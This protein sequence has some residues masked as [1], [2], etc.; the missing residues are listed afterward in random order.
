[1]KNFIYVFTMVMMAMGS[2]LQAQDDTLIQRIFETWDKDSN[3]FIDLS[4]IK[5]ILI[6]SEEPDSQVDDIAQGVLRSNDANGDGHI[7]WE[8]FS[9]TYTEPRVERDVYDI[10]TKGIPKF[11]SSDYIALDKIA[12]IS[13]FRSGIGHDF[14]DAFES[15]RNM[16]H[17]YLPYPDIDW[18]T[19]PI[20]SPVQGTIHRLFQEWAGTQICIKSSQYP[21]FYF[22]IFHVHLESHLAVGDR[23]MSGQL[24]GYHI[25]QQTMSDIA[26]S[27][28]TPQGEKL[29]SFFDTMM[30]SLFAKYQ[31]RGIVNRSD[32][33]ISK[34]QRDADPL[35]CDEEGNFIHGGHLE[36]WVN[37]NRTIKLGKTNE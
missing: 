34:E 9:D 23:V 25:G 1:M 31:K 5:R 13:K 21:A 11:V 22:I 17:Y 10:N 29:I 8:E 14:S 35:E 37:L 15:K 18:T 6:V 27:I 16:K 19:V 36:N 4:E 24:L 12:Q 3:G 20:Y 32:T 26:V 7:S 30:D 28:D 33:I 2:I